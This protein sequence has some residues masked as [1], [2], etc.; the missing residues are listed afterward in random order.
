MESL[1][2]L[3]P[4]E[5]IIEI[6]KYARKDFDKVKDERCVDIY[7]K[8][9]D[10]IKNGRINPDHF[11]NIKSFDPQEYYHMSYI[12]HEMSDNQMFWNINSQKISFECE[13]SYKDY[14]YLAVDIKNLDLKDIISKHIT[15]GV[16]NFRDAL[17]AVFEK[18]IV[19][20]SYSNNIIERD[21]YRRINEYTIIAKFKNEYIFFHGT[22]FNSI[23]D[24]FSGGSFCFS[25]SWEE[26]WNKYLTDIIR[27]EFLR[28]QE[29][30]TY[31]QSLSKI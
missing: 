7:N 20:Y 1:F 28:N 25:S 22:S 24:D 26:L 10:K 5:M 31:P 23:Y 2:D 14:E 19:Y 21:D 11:F 8:I 4:E 29:Y 18:G 6:F 30:Y 3:L 9:M 13:H 15:V 12:F 27:D 17:E 16:P